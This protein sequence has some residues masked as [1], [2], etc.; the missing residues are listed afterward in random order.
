M[1]PP[2]PFAYA[3]DFKRVLNLTSSKVRDFFNWL[4]NLKNFVL[5]NESENMQKCSS[6]SI[7]RAIFYK[8]NHKKS[9]SDWG[10]CP[11]APITFCGWELRF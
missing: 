8:K 3:D 4:S 9:P 5:S 6:N 1:T 2:A 10:L 7:K 11:Q